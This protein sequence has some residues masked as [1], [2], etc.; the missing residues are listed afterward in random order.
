[1]IA[2]GVIAIVGPLAGIDPLRAHRYL[3][4]LAQGPG[5]LLG[6]LGYTRGTTT[7]GTGR[8]AH[9]RVPSAGSGR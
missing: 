1:M 9:Y 6:R 2:D 8:A 7:S 4:K 5:N 3:M